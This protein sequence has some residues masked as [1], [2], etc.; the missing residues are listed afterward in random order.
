MGYVPAEALQAAR[1]EEPASQRPF[2]TGNEAAEDEEDDLLPPE[3]LAAVVKQ[4]RSAPFRK[5]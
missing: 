1:G 5:E 3:V 4:S 2:S